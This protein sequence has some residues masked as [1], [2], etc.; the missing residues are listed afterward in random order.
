M[1]TYDVISFQ[2]NL[3]EMSKVFNDYRTNPSDKTNQRTNNHQE[4]TMRE[5]PGLPVQKPV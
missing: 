1:I 2:K 5:V 3:D 4:L